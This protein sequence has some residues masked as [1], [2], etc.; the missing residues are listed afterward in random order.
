MD[1]KYV[2]RLGYW[3]QGATL[4]PISTPLRSTGMPLYHS[5]GK[6]PSSSSREIHLCFVL[7]PL[8]IDGNQ[9]APWQFHDKVPP[10][11]SSRASQRCLV[12]STTTTNTPPPPSST[13]RTSGSGSHY[14]DPWERVEDTS[15]PWQYQKHFSQG[16]GN[17]DHTPVATIKM[18][19]NLFCTLANL[20]I[21]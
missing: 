5:L 4:P 12:G 18:C 13:T 15:G 16:V 20:E 3:W 10:S 19:Q 9:G 14:E 6:P 11:S 1:C 8:L 7:D 21:F 2:S 17:L